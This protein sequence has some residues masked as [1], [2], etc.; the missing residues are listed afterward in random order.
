[1]ICVVWC[2]N[3]INDHIKKTTRT[4]S[5]VTYETKRPTATLDLSMA[6]LKTFNQLSMNTA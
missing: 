4:S 2:Q 1:M 3:A 5:R 6:P